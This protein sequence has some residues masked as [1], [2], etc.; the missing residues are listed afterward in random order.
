MPT[1]SEGGEGERGGEGNERGGEGRGEE[2]REGKERGEEGE[3]RRR[4]KGK[5]RW[6]EGEERERDMVLL[7]PSDPLNWIY[8]LWISRELTRFI[9]TQSIIL[10]RALVGEHA[11]EIS[12]LCALSSRLHCNSPSTRKR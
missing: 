12:A 8:L 6:G 1:P 11:C 7:S 9:M 5:G 10:C 4:E 3:G 2:R